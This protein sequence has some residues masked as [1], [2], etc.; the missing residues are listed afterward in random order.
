[1]KREDLSICAPTITLHQLVV[2]DCI[3]ET[4]DHRGDLRIED[5]M[6]D[7]IAEVKDDFDVLPGGMKHLDDLFIGHQPEKRSKI[8]A[9]RQRVDDGGMIGR[10]AAE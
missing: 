1:M 8:K 5:R 2:G 7:Q 6:R 4:A 3:A 10:C 9:R